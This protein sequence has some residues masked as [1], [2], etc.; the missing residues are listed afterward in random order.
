MA[1][2]LGLV[3]EFEVAHGGRPK[4]TGSRPAAKNRRRRKGASRA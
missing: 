3:R 4:P 2:N 1:G